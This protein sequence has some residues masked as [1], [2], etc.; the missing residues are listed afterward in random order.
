MIFVLVH[1]VTR[2]RVVINVRRDFKFY[3]K[4]W[5]L[6]KK[7]YLPKNNE[8]ILDTKMDGGII[9]QEFISLWHIS[10]ILFLFQ[11]WI[12]STT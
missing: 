4:K 1:A 5:K 11:V 6:E 10:K 2:I 8:E 7:K 3:N 9:D 12:I